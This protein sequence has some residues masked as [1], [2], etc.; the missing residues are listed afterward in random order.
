MVDVRTRAIMQPMIAWAKPNG[1]WGTRMPAPPFSTRMP[2]I[3]EP[4]RRAAVNRPHVS[5]AANRTERE[6]RTPQRT[7]TGSL[8]KDANCC[9]IRLEEESVGGYWGGGGG[10]LVRSADLGRSRRRRCTSKP[11]AGASSD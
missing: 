7:K 4:S 9:I 6:T 5:K 1:S 3:I 8:D 10:G 2:A 11:L